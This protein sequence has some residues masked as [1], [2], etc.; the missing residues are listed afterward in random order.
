MGFFF[1][2]FLKGGGVDVAKNIE[3]NKHTPYI[4]LLRA[5]GTYWKEYGN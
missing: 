4:M 2:F 3:I 5:L 1:F